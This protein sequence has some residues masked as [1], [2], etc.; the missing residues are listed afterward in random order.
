MAATSVG[1][2]TTVD[3][4]QFWTDPA[5]KPVIQEMV[6]EFEKQNPDIDVQLT[7]LTWANGH[8]KIV[9]SLSSGTGPDVVELGSDWIA[10]FAESGHLYDIGSMIAGDSAEYDGWSMA[11][12]NNGVWGHPWILGTRVVFVNRDLLQRAGYDPTWLPITL[13]QF[14]EAIGKVDSLGADIYGWGSNTAEKHRLY[15]KF[16][17]FL[18]SFGGQL[19]SDDMEYCLLASDYAINALEYYRT[20]H[21]EFGYV[22]NQRGIEDAF[23]DGKVGFIL[24]GEWLLKRIRNENRTVNFE[25]T[26]FPGQEYPGHSFKGGEFL[27]VN[28]AS[29]NKEAAM[30]LIQF[31]TSPENQVKFCRANLSANP[32]SRSAQRDEYFAGDEHLSTFIRQLRLSKHP[33]VIPEWVSV[34][35]ILEEALEDLLFGDTELVSDRLLEARLKIERVMAE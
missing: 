11:Q 6:A 16:L 8:E 31:V 26:V 15:K 14:K 28:A 20:L 19:F 23:L 5:I 12:W 33:P 13:D 24:S 22:A 2:Q 27:S 34:E 30:K 10:Q 9:I 35:T 4:W 17:P 18:W 1:A 25:T 7:D 32:S 3:W 29:D 21:D